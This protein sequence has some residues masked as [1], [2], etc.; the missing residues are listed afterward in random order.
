[1]ITSEE[2]LK[3]RD[4]KFVFEIVKNIKAIFGKPV[5]GKKRKKLEKAPKDSPFKMQKYGK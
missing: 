3:H 5:K 2:T 1:M 4:G